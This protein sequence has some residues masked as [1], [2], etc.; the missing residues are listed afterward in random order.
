MPDAEKWKLV[1]DAM[2]TARDALGLLWMSFPETDDNC[3]AAR[4]ALDAIEAAIEVHATTFPTT[5]HQPMSNTTTPQGIVILAFGPQPLDFFT[6]AQKIIGK[7]AVLNPDVAR[8]AGAS[9]AVGPQ[10]AMDALRQRLEAGALEAETKANP[11]LS[12]AATRWL[13]C[14]ERGV[15]SNS[16][17]KHLTAIDALQGRRMDVPKD[18]A[19][20]R[21]CRLLLE[22]VPELAPRFPRMAEVSEAWANLVRSWDVICATMDEECPRWRNIPGTANK[23][24]NLIKIAI[25]R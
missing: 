16:I 19:D 2:Q 7:D 4:R 23:T 25:G 3:I 11:G 10:N 17:F 24:Y 22:Q 21:R 9:F 18:P 13:A 1:H 5:T 8:M 15:S 14:G 20:L 12:E 6:K